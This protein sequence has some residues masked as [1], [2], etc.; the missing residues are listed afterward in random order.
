[1]FPRVKIGPGN[2][3]DLK[4]LPSKSTIRRHYKILSSKGNEFY[5]R[6]ETYCLSKINM[7]INFGIFAVAKL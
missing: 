2:V 5:T 1:M 7:K 6:S 3:R 4:K